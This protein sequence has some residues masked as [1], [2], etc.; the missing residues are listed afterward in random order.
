MGLVWAAFEIP[1]WGN[2]EC[3]LLHPQLKLNFSEPMAAKLR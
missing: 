2:C 1:T 3:V